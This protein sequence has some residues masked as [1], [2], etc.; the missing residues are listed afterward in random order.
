[1]ANDQDRPGVAGAGGGQPPPGPPAP[2]PIPPPPLPPLR[3]ILTP[4]NIALLVFAGLALAIIIIAIFSALV[5][6][7][8]QQ[9]FLVARL[10]DVLL[11][12]AVISLTLGWLSPANTQM[13]G[14][15][16]R[17]LL[18]IH[19]AAIASFVLSS[20]ATIGILFYV[21]VATASSAEIQHGLYLLAAIE[22][23]L[24]LTAVSAIIVLITLRRAPVIVP[25]QPNAA[26]QPG[27]PIV[28]DDQEERGRLEFGS[29]AFAFGLVVIAG[30]VVPTEDLMRLTTMFFGD[31]KAVEDYLPARPLV[32]VEQD[33]SEQIAQAVL[34]S[35]VIQNMIDISGSNE[36]L[37][38]EEIRRLTDKLI[39]SAVM[40][41]VQT[42]GAYPLL[43]AI[44]EGKQDDFIFPNSDDRLL[45]E[46][47]SYLLTAGLVEYPYGDIRTLK[48]TPYGVEILTVE[49]LEC[50]GTFHALTEVDF[51][52]PVQFKQEA[53][54]I[55][56][57][58]NYQVIESVPH[59]EDVA[60]SAQGTV[61]K[62]ALT[63]GR[64]AIHLQSV[65]LSDPLVELYDGNG[66]FVSDDDDSGTQGYDA[67]LT[68]RVSADEKYFLRAVSFNGAPATAS[69]RVVNYSDTAETGPS[70]QMLQDLP[71]T[72]LPAEADIPVE[73][74]VFAF[75][76]IETG[77]HVIHIS[78]PPGLPPGNDLVATLYRKTGNVYEYLAED[79]DTGLNSLPIVAASLTEGDTFYLAVRHYDPSVAS[80]AK[81]RIAVYP[82]VAPVSATA[83]Q[84]EAPPPEMPAPDVA[85]ANP[86]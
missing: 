52:G 46:H 5:P 40:D 10:L 47:L 71:A 9:G 63:E 27:A 84:S 69:L 85:P 77:E 7:Q 86:L 68:F 61:R 65:D 79:D 11:I 13:L 34:V 59:Q 75:T 55:D 19:R 23:L 32:T 15:G 45:A 44:C 37:I 12:A 1:M 25:A 28:V 70:E 20:A 16:F 21:V 50:A 6:A 41:G 62:L 29:L 74:S 78:L 43:A 73:G 26:G 24:K 14:L 22:F 72:P 39:A 76:A 80:P 60:I 53:S 3:G 42:V 36:S 17:H 33:L 51:S 35:P 8:P 82:G 58:Q 48:M 38:S 31:D 4:Q 57:A 30:L 83:D 49:R 18:S 66:N 2:P 54:P 64:Y 81:I 67:L 56:T